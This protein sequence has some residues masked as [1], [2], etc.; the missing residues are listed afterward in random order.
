MPASFGVGG[1]LLRQ[2]VLGLVVLGVRSWNM[3]LLVRVLF[4][5]N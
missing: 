3:A 5:R 1:K 2:L 4:R